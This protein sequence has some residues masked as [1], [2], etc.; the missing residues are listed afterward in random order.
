VCVVCS[1]SG[2]LFLF[3]LDKVVVLEW[4]G[5]GWA[6]SGNR[7][8]GWVGR[9]V[10]FNIWLHGGWLVTEWYGRWS[11]VACKVAWFWGGQFLA[12]PEYDA[13][14]FKRGPRIGFCFLDVSKL[15]VCVI[16]YIISQRSWLC[17]AFGKRRASA[18]FING[19]SGG[20]GGI[21]NREQFGNSNRSCLLTAWKCVPRHS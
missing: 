3:F 16:H 14:F 15:C 8:V 5:S 19:C 7:S 12:Q 6:G 10:V 9:W 21:K 18:C 4:G 11:L 17:L 13:C 2:V 20:G 1:I